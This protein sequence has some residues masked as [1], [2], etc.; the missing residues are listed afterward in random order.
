[1]AVPSN[2]HV[3]TRLAARRA[4]LASV[5]DVTERTVAYRAS[6]KASFSIG[7]QLASLLAKLVFEV[8]SKGNAG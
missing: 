4:E 8:G 2:W 3:D 5:D 1:M 6:R 7:G